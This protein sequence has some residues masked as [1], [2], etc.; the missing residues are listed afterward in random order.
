MSNFQWLYLFKGK[1]GV[2]AAE[3]KKKLNSVGISPA[4]EAGPTS[5]G[6]CRSRVQFDNGPTQAAGLDRAAVFNDA[7]PTRSIW[8]SIVV[9]SGNASKLT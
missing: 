7:A 3:G 4:D 1:D 5:L 2:A 9:I 6:P 8:A